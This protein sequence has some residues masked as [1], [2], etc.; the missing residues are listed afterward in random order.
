MPVISTLEAIL[1]SVLPVFTQP[2]G[3]LF[4]RLVIGWIVC[5]S[6]HTVTGILSYADPDGLRSHDSYHRFFRAG[7]WCTTALFRAWSAVLVRWLCPSGPLW[8]LTDDTVHKKTGR[9]MDGAAWCRDAVRSTGQHVVYVWGLKVVPLCLRVI[10][11]WGGEPLALPVAIRLYR[12][13]GPSLLERVEEMV[14]DLAAGF[15][16]RAFYLTA[17][18]FY[19]PLAGRGLPRTHVISRIRHDAALYAKPPARR[20]GKLGRPAKRGR[21]LPSPA[22][23]PQRVRS[24]KRMETCERGKPRTRLVYTRRVLWYHVCPDREVLLV[25][26]RDPEGKEKDDFFVTTDLTLAPAVVISEFANR[27]P[28]E[29]TFRNVKQYLGAEHPQCWKGRGP[30]RAA[31]FAY[32]LYGVIWL[33]YIRHG[34]A[35]TSLPATP[36]YRQKATPSFADARAALR[37]ALW[38]KRL[39]QTVPRKAHLKKLAMLLVHALARAA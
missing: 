30:E 15:P 23:M 9:K 18:G 38:H 17:D 37:E 12:K 6:R 7:A 13:G 19:A 1:L 22:E 31:A 3:Q 39:F 29:D 14:N 5:P 16:E 10:P 4:L 11:P 27:W 26:S 20:K 35:S 34:Y 36:W 28:I 8:L 33:W 32:F 25:I 21:R 24:W 2:S